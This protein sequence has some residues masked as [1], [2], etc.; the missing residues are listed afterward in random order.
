MKKTKSRPCLFGL[1]VGGI[2]VF[3]IFSTN[4]SALIYFNSSDIAFEESETGNTFLAK[5][6]QVPILQG[7]LPMNT[8]SLSLPNNYQYSTTKRLSDYIKD[9]AMNFLEAY[10]NFLL[11]LKEIEASD[12]NKADIKILQDTIDLM[13]QAKNNY[14][15]LSEKAEK[16]SYKEAI[17]GK[18]KN[19]DYDGFRETNHLRKDVFDKVKALLSS[20]DI[21]GA[22]KEALSQF[23]S[24]LKVSKNI[25]GNLKSG[26]LSD[27]LSELLSLNQ[28]YSESMFFG[29]YVAQVFGKLEAQ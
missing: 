1:I 2:F 5:V 25:R 11:F 13:E 6:L 7:I 16:L 9:G 18:L 21:R 8:V 24:I 10:S 4:L 17:I 26:K 28:L 22:Y 23:N 20:V 27:L 12:A 3:M 14:T 15:E 19:F 29:Q